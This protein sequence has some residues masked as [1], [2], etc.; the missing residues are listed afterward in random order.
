MK[1]DRILNNELELLDFVESSWKQKQG[2]RQGIC[3]ETGKCLVA[4]FYEA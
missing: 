1:I 4:D 2:R 3:Q